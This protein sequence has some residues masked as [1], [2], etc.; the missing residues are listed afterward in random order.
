MDLMVTGRRVPA[1]EALEMGLLSRVVPAATCAARPRRWSRSWPASR[2]WRCGWEGGL[3]RGHGDAA[4]AGLAA[5]QAQL[6]L[7]NTTEDASEGVRSFQE[8]RPPQWKGR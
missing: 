6:S 4:R 7:L 8:K 1:A 2:R 3:R 5:M